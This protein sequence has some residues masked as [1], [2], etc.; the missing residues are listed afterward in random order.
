M[1][2]IVLGSSS[3]GNGYALRDSQGKTLL[4]EAG[5]RLI[6][7]K[8]SLGFNTQGLLGCLV[9]HKHGDHIKYVSQYLDA[10]IDVYTGKDNGVNGHRFKGI[11]PRTQ[12]E[13]GPFS[14]IPFEVFHDV[15]TFGFLIHHEESGTFC[16]ITDTAFSKYTFPGLNNVII[17]ANYS[18]EIILRRFEQGEIQGFLK[19]RVMRSHLSFENTLEFLRVNDLSKVQKI[20][21]I[22]LSEGNADPVQFERKTREFTGKRVEI[23]KK[24]RTIQ[25][26]KSPF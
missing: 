21:L 1:D 10:G 17:E 7:V 18:R 6:E 3:A 8:K 4:I 20:V 11:E 15:E 16:F 22:H 19:D 24:G 9:T 13:I 12:F 23:A 2:L 14:I 25:L 26:S 5:V